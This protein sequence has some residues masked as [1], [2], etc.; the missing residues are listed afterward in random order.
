MSVTYI[1][2]KAKPGMEMDLQRELGTMD[3]L[4]DVVPLFGEYDFIVKLNLFSSTKLAEFILKNLR[5]LKGI[6]STKS[7]TNF[8]I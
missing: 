2:I 4:E 3:E 8:R 7:L 6:R 5:T 1:L